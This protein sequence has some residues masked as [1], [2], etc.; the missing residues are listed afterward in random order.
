MEYSDVLRTVCL[1]DQGSASASVDL[2]GGL[3]MCFAA[4]STELLV[5]FSLTSGTAS[6]GASDV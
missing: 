6:A 3:Q 4:G 2:T 5:A 1:S